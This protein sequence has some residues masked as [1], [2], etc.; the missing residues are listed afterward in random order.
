[1]KRLTGFHMWFHV[2]CTL[3]VHR[4]KERFNI[5]WYERI[6][7][8]GC[9]CCKVCSEY[10]CHS[11]KLKWRSSLYPSTDGRKSKHGSGEVSTA[12]RSF[13]KSSAVTSVD[14][15]WRGR[16]RCYFGIREGTRHQGSI[17]TIMAFLSKCWAMPETKT[18]NVGILDQRFFQVWKKDRKKS[19]VTETYPLVA[20]N[21]LKTHRFY[22]DI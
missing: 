13:M 1:M 3:N 8:M 18:R 2:W 6:M 11:D 5:L 20:Y 15:I 7:L 12:F 14:A 22:D 21:N 10:S 16:E 19:M 4:L 17:K 9:R